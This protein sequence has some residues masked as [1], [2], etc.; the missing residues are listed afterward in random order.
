MERKGG[1]GGTRVGEQYG[2]GGNFGIRGGFKLKMIDSSVWELTH[3]RNLTQY[4]HKFLILNGESNKRTTLKFI[5]NRKTDT[6]C[7]EKLT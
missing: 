7:K 2:K 6:S 4:T 3:D 1:K 5:S